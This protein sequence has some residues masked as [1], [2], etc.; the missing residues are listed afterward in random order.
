[1]TIEEAQRWLEFVADLDRREPKT[2]KIV[3]TKSDYKPEVAR[4]FQGAALSREPVGAVYCRW[5][6][7]LFN[8]AN[9]PE[10]PNMN[11]VCRHRGEILP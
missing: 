7:M 1:M 5:C 3:R 10:C 11:S 2:P 8:T 6:G 4:T 9:R